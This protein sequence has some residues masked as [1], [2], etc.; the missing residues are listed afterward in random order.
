MSSLSTFTLI[1]AA[2]LPVHIAQAQDVAASATR[3]PTIERVDPPSWWA[4]D[5]PQELTLL[6]EGSNLGDAR[7][8]FARSLR[9]EQVE[10]GPEG[11]SLFVDV[12]L[13]P[14]IEPGAIEIEVEAGGHTARHPWKILDRPATPPRSLGADDVIYLV[15]PDRFADGDPSN[16]EPEGPDRLL[17]RR[18]PHA[19][20]GGDF[21]G[22]RRRLPYLADLGVTAL[23]ITPIYRQA[24]R[25]FT[26]T[27]AGRARR[28][29]DFHGYS[30]VDVYDTNPRFGDPDEY[31]RLVDEAHRLGLKVIQDHVVGHVGPQHRWL[32]HAPAPG[33]FHGPID[34]PPICTFRLEAL[35]DPHAPEAERRG[36]TDGWFLGLLPDLDTRNPKVRRYAI[37]QSLW[38]ATLFEADAIRLD[39]YPMVDRDFWRD[40]SRRLKAERPGLRAVGEAWI[41]EPAVLSFFQGGRAGW[42]GIDPGVESVF[43]FPLSRAIAEV[44]SG[45]APA[46]QLARALSRDGLY[47]HPEW[48]VTFLD[49]HD[50]MRLAAVPGVSPARLRLAAAFLLTTRG[51]PQMTWGDELGLPGHMDDRRDFPGGFPGD[52]RDA[53]DPAGRTAEEQATFRCYRDLIR[54]RRASPALC[55][56]RLTHLVADATTYTFL[57]EHAGERLVVAL[58]L[59]AM[60]AVL[61]VAAD[62]VGQA[63]AIERVYGAGRATAGSDSLRAEMPP[64]SVGVFR[65]GP[66][67]GR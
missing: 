49:N 46:S 32:A 40:W 60:P 56:G 22:L 59:G 44:F 65:L 51:I 53:F 19:Y 9:V 20:H 2:T 15:M 61:R 14:D 48:L 10:A 5:R 6:I 12:T 42:D 17:D 24:P 29:A 3:G 52:P 26:T 64:E 16:N 33:W 57:R 63:D 58:N 34:R 31:R 41:E 8:R 55:H 30:A 21:R 23:W 50:T 1:I 13:P 7:P 43:D 39:T 36:V 38:W 62:R 11:R 37:Q 66:A 27:G 45:R 54:L 4:A 35:A 18:D 28:F 25:W 67:D 47:P